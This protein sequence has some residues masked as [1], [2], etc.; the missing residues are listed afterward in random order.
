[1]N[2]LNN[3]KYHHV[4]YKI[5]YQQLNNIILY[6]IHNVNHQYKFYNYQFNL[7]NIYNLKNN[8]R[9]NKHNII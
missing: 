8:I 6:T 2:I 7:I 9:L 4:Y 3:V 1:M 5:F